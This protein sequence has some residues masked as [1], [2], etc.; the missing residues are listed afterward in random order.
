MIIP[1]EERVSLYLD[2][3]IGGLAMNV[4]G[5][6]PLRLLFHAF[7]VVVG[8]IILSGAVNTAIVGFQRGSQPRCRGRGAPGLVS[9]SAQEIRH[10][11][12]PYHPGRR[13]PDNYYYPDPREY[14]VAGR[15][16]CVRHRLELRH[17]G[18]VRIG[19]AI[20]AA[21]EPEWKV[22]LNLRVKGKEL[23]LG[24]D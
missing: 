16:L 20:Q 8:T 6:L 9:H 7:V 11:R 1:D 18:L 23:P 4:V 24:L 13:T 14:S 17:A 5:P 22:P 15:C 19:F 21:E 12:T 2:N 3:L 10:H